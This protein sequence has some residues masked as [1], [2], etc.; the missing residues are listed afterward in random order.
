MTTIRVSS[1]LSRIE[2]LAWL[3]INAARHN[4][5]NINIVVTESK[6]FFPNF[7]K[8]WQRQ[9]I[10]FYYADDLHKDIVQIPQDR[11]QQ[12]FK[13]AEETFKN[14]MY[15]REPD[16][17]DYN[18]GAIGIKIDFKTFPVLDVTTYCKY[19]PT[20]TNFRSLTHPKIIRDLKN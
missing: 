11:L 8:I 18:S 17:V 13:D 20:R 16:Y 12:Y 10:G 6:P 5:K 14:G 15:P 2:T 9:S 4:S 19:H 3:H 7:S 1:C